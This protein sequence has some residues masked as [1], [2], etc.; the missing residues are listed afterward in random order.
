MG[1]IEL[2]GAWAIIMI[3]GAYGFFLTVLRDVGRGECGS[4]SAQIFPNRIRAVAVAL[5]TAA[6]WIGNFLVSTTFPPLRDSLGL[7]W[8]FALYAV[9]AVLGYW[10]IAKKLPETNG[11]ELEDMKA[12]I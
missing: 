1:G 3:I 4:S 8:T 11:V 6:N 10:F 7:T 5:A 2:P 9:M 12:E